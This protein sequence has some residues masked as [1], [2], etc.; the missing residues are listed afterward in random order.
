[1]QDKKQK[2]LESDFKANPNYWRKF[3]KRFGGIVVCSN[4][5][6][7]PITYLN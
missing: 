7:Q 2:I 5:T 1:M 3:A 6:G 4:Q